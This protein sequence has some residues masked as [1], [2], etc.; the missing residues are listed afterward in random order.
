V[1]TTRNIA[2]DANEFAGKRALVTGGSRGIGEAIVKRLRDGGATVMTTAR[3]SGADLEKPEL[4]VQADISTTAG[5]ETVIKNVLDRLGG[6]D[7]LVSNVGGSSAPGG[8]V[9]ALSDT[10]WQETF[11]TN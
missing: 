8:G 10:D 9:L 4:F 1:T 11:N 3:S 7:I 6:V 5:V 2:V